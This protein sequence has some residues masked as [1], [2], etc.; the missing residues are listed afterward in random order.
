[1]RQ[2]RHVDTLRR[3]K[4]QCGDKE[5]QARELI[6]LHGRVGAR[7][8]KPHSRQHYGRQNLKDVLIERRNESLQ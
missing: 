8:P 4:L 5:C 7:T 2:V 6:F 3:M 1:L